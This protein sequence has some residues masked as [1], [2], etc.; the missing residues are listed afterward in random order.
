[1]YWKGGAGEATRRLSANRAVSHI[2]THLSFDS[3]AWFALRR[4]V[5]APAF[6]FQYVGEVCRRSKNIKKSCKLSSFPDEMLI[7]LSFFGYHFPF[8]Q[9]VFTELTYGQLYWK[10][11][12]FLKTVFFWVLYPYYKYLSSISAHIEHKQ[13]WNRGSH[14]GK[15]K[16]NPP[17][18]KLRKTCFW[19]RQFFWPILLALSWWHA[20]TYRVHRPP[21]P[22]SCLREVAA[23]TY[24]EQSRAMIVRHKRNS[25]F[26]SIFFLKNSIGG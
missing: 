10:R 9:K 6:P 23:N 24:D 17:F 22:N 11:C 20:P 2:W 1:M 21:A 7:A 25:S 19:S 4:P 18:T 8:F 3:P 14:Q 26:D 5:A 15:I 16:W 12:P 13:K